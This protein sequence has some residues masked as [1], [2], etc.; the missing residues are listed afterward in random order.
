M[1]ALQVGGGMWSSPA[2]L[3]DN[4]ADQEDAEVAVIV[5]AESEDLCDEALRCSR[6]T[7]R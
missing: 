5:V 4:I 7:G 3:L 2:P 1:K 6:W